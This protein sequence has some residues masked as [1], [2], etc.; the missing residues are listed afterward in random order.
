M[1]G[2]A[3]G[4]LSKQ[5]SITGENGFFSTLPDGSS[6]PVETWERRH[7]WFIITVLSHIPFLLALGLYDSAQSPIA[8]ATIPAMPTGRVL[9]QIGIIAGFAF[10]AAIPQLS[11]RLR[12]TLAVTGL[13]F[14][15]GALVHFSGGYIEAHF[16]FFVAIGIA[17]IYEDWIPFG[18]GIVYV[19]ISHI[20][21]G[22]VEPSMVYNHTAAQLHPVVWGGIHGGF[23]L[24]L[25]GALTLHLSSIEESRRKAQAELERAKERATQID[26]LEEER[27]EIEQQREEAQQLK[28]E[29]EKERKEVEAL[30]SHIEL[31]AQEYR[32]AMGSLADGDLTARVDTESQNEAMAEIGA[33]FNQMAAELEETVSDIQSVTESVDREVTQSESAVQEISQASDGV[34]ESVQRIATGADEQRGKIQ[35]ASEEVSEFSAAVEEIAASANEVAELSGETADIA[36]DGQAVADDTLEDAQEVKTS[37]E[38]TVETVTELDSQM[39]EIAEIVDLI[40]DIAEQ[41]NMLA[42]NANIEA[43][44]ADGGSDGH[45]GD[46][47][48]VVADEVK[49]LAEETQDSAGD[50]QS[51]IES[52][53]Q[54]TGTVVS[55]VEQA[56]GLVAKEIEAVEEVVDAFE[57][58]AEN[59]E[60]TDVGV[61][62]I[63]QT[64]DSQASA[65]ENVVSMID[66]VAEI[67]AD[68]ADETE[69]VSATVQEQTA[70][71]DEVSGN[72]QILTD[73]ARELEQAVGEFTVQRTE[74]HSSQDQP[75]Q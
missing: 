45:S 19:L 28:D 56:S 8:G 24:M 9:L 61:K 51:R 64:T 13:A 54:Q 23:V 44:R 41:T 49:Q 36:D 15:T 70:A 30:N 20:L 48:A 4:D 53:Q 26:N 46:G 10:A 75:A 31:K 58:V 29:A 33:T 22:L 38:K 7:K 27:T 21:F 5:Q 35:Q 39:D 32:E 17:A 37:I 1:G 42:L 60:E 47:F 6:I 14:C 50:I 55:Q 43:A 25:A 69:S 40:S 68:S 57:Q 11:R 16:H 66:E 73:R 2:H 52:V 59:A 34:S 74:I 71:L 12:T 63:N 62:E 72:M 3:G 18:V 65:S 67:S